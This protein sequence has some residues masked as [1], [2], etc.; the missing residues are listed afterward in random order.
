[1]K[2]MRRLQLFAALVIALAAAAMP[3]TA[4]AASSRVEPQCPVDFYPVSPASCPDGM[5]CSPNEIL[6]IGGLTM[7]CGCFGG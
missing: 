7:E 4:S 1:M 5:Q 2:S 3:S 6:C